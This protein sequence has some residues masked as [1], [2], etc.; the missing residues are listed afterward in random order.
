MMMTVEISYKCD[1]CDSV[2]REPAQFYQMS[3]G[4]QGLIGQPNYRPSILKWAKIQNPYTICQDCFH[5]LITPK[6]DLSDDSPTIQ[7]LL[8]DMVEDATMAYM[9]DSR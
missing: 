8:E 1:K 4:Y 9:E 5:E 7:S 3:I 2:Q 6:P